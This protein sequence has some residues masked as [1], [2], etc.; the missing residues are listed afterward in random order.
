MTD[1][2]A[3]P[4]GTL[5]AAHCGSFFPGLRSSRKVTVGCGARWIVVMTLDSTL[6]HF[7]FVQSVSREELREA[8]QPFVVGR[9]VNESLL[10]AMEASAEMVEAQA[11]IPQ[12]AQAWVGSA[13]AAAERERHDQQ[14]LEDLAGMQEIQR[15][16]QA[17]ADPSRAPST[18][19]PPNQDRYAALAQSAEEE[20]ERQRRQE[21]ETRRQAEETRREEA[22]RARQSRNDRNR[23][24]R[25]QR[26]RERE[27]RE[28]RE[29]Q[30]EAERIERENTIPAGARNPANRKIKL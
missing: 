8:L 16:L 14:L 19:S 28:A 25:E 2:P 6:G 3:F 1:E 4:I 24:R 9:V 22:R 13:E 21:E 18:W 30:E 29:A 23:R 27:E 10:S 7:G 12:W 26:Q 20:R 5:F 15:R 11:S 17:A